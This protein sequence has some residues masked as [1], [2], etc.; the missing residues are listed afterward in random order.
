MGMVYNTDVGGLWFVGS[1][2]AEDILK[3]L[4]DESGKVIVLD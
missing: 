2:H 1:D 4:D 3:Y